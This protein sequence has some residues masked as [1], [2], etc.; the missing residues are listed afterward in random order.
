MGVLH[1]ADPTQPSACLQGCG[2]LAIVNGLPLK[3]HI[4]VENILL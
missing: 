3:K 4:P 2:D 1:G